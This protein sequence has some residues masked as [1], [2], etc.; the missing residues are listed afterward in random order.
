MT[1]QP[2]DR[3][4]SLEPTFTHLARRRQLVDAAIAVIADSGLAAASTVQIA[5]RAGASRGVLTHHFADREELIDAVVSEVYELGRAFVVPIMQAADGPREQVLA[6][7]SASVELYGAHPEH[8]AALKEIFAFR[9][10]VGDAHAREPLHTRELR[11][12]AAALLREG[13]RRGELRAF[14]P[15]TMALLIRSILDAALQ[16]I[17][18]GAP[19]PALR[20]EVVAVVDLATR[21]EA[22]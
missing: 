22:P 7:V 8:L 6:F 16:G 1:Q 19:L 5:L 17:R 20:D 11:D 12:V 15:N 13:Q 21:Q 10:R 9:R 14:D 3:S 4:R 18:E 2:A